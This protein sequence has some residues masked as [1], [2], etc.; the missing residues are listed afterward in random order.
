[1]NR[2]ILIFTDNYPFGRSEPFFDTELQFIESSFERVSLIPFET[3]RDKNKRKIPEKVEVI[4]APFIE[5]KKKIYLIKKGI[6]NTSFLFC[7]LKESI[8]SKIW[9]SVTKIKIWATHLLVIRSLLSDIKQRAL[10]N[11][12]NQFDVLYFYWGLRWSQILPFLPSE[13][14]AKIVVRFHGSDLY[15][16]TNSNY[17]PW[18][19]EQLSRL[20]KAVVISETGKKYIEN[21]YSFLKER[22][23]VSRIGTKDFGLNP[24]V[25]SDTIRIVSCSNLVPVKRVGLIVATL[26]FLKLPVSWVHFGDGPKMKEIKNSASRLPVHIK[27]DMKGAV[28]HDELMDYLRSSPV[29]I[30]INVSSS[31]GVPVSIM[32][33]MSFGIPVIAT[34]AG[35]TSEVVSEKTGLLIDV[36]FSPEELARRIE[37]FVKRD[38]LNEIRIA[39]RK[40]WEN[41][42]MAENV[43]PSFIYQLLII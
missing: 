26:S 10:I 15:E 8:T 20:S 21:H 11:F 33:A 12:F 39:A 17:I 34:N 25:R 27:A 14:R 6:F 18:R 30:F 13:I 43:Y 16:H 28:G 32:E 4:S 2:T 5:S 42:S 3:G 1:M 37:S 35:G 36:D 29:D 38:D 19:H 23:I 31:E 9:M 7:F 22:I 40:E 24:S 41:K